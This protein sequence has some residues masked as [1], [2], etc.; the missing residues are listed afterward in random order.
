MVTTQAVL[1]KSSKSSLNLPD[2]SGGPNGLDNRRQF[3]SSGVTLNDYKKSAESE[4][5]DCSGR[6][7]TG[8]NAQKNSGSLLM[9][10]RRTE[11]EL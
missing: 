4:L 6:G 2:N 1:T 11:R 10:G 8:V 7:G 5:C 9:D 3:W